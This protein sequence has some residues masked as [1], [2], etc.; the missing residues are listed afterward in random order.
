M[1][2]SR[3]KVEFRPVA[4][5][6]IS[7]D[8]AN[9]T[10]RSKEP[11]SAEGGRRVAVIASLTLS[12]VNFRLELLK[13]MTE[14]GHDVVAF[15]PEDD[16][17]TVGVLEDIG[18]RFIQI[19]MARTGLNPLADLRT[20]FVLWRHFRKIRPD[21]VLPYTMKPIIYGGLAARLAG[22]PHRFALITGLGHVFRDARPA[23]PMAFVRQISIW[24]YRSALAGAERV[25]VYNDAD[26]ADVC[27][28]RMIA[29]MSR[30]MAV[31]GSGVDLDRFCRSVPPHDPPVFLLIARLLHDKGIVD[32][33]EAAR[34]LRQRHENVRF[35]L[36]GPFDPN[37]TAISRA[38]VDG[39]VK[40]GVIEY[41]GETRDVRP[42]LAACSAFVLPSYYREGIPRTIL[43]AMATGRAIITA[44]TPGCRDTVTNGENGLLVPPRQPEKLAK[45]MEAL[46]NEPELFTAMGERSH[47]FA[48]ERFDVH[49]V[50]RLL[51]SEMGL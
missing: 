24:L 2:D 34:N 15:A 47:H 12:L 36:L 8:N 23:G 43:E 50:N 35:Q 32:Y 28:N 20:L 41:L 7:S 29:D 3:R 21:T 5:V 17:E 9:M 37:P 27:K 48:R 4:I 45:A 38:D 25:F 46:L 51:L 6:F 19:P 49:A 16:A 31:P 13:R 42:Y 11:V 44:D 10:D 33:V 1:L 40:E 22:V 26:A 14:A 39:W 18:V 30:M